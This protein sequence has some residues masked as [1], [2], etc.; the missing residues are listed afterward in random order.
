MFPSAIEQSSSSRRTLRSDPPRNFPVPELRHSHDVGAFLAPTT[1]LIAK[2]PSG[3]A[4]FPRSSHLPSSVPARRIPPVTP[5]GPPRSHFRRRR[6]RLQASF[7]RREREGATGRVVATLHFEK[8]SSFDREARL[9][10]FSPRRRAS[11]GRDGGERRRRAEEPPRTGVRP[12]RRPRR[13]GAG[14]PTA[15]GGPIAGTAAGPPLR[16]FGSRS[17]TPGTEGRSETAGDR[18]DSNGSR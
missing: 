9:L 17:A 4:A 3:A 1:G 18:R 6:F 13:D 15:G 7:R 2:G 8:A 12:C 5:R 16:R 10:V 14:A 11:P